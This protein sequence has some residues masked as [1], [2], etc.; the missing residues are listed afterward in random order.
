MIIAMI[1][2]TKIF[3]SWSAYCDYHRNIDV[4]LTNTALSMMMMMNSNK[5]TISYDGMMV[6][7]LITMMM[8]KED[9]EV[10]EP[11]Q[12]TSMAYMVV[13]R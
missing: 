2:P 1:T 10:Q 13:G 6:I 5:K 8:L 7:D 3:C 4:D 9:A 11:T 12:V